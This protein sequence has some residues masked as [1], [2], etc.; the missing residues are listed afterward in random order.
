MTLRDFLQDDIYCIN[1][2]TKRKAVDKKPN[3]VNRQTN[4]MMLK[5]RLMTYHFG[6]HLQAIKFRSVVTIFRT[7]IFIPLYFK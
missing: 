7:F 6:L 1:A 3:E 5:K 4:L 2:L